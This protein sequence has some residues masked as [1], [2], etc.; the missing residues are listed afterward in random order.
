MSN[1]VLDIIVHNYKVFF[2]PMDYQTIALFIRSTKVSICNT[3]V[4]VA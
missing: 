4:S 2:I 3:K 1:M